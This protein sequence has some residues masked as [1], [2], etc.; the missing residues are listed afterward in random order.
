MVFS[1]TLKTT[2]ISPFLW[3]IQTPL[4]P[5]QA[6]EDIDLVILVGDIHTTSHGLDWAA[7]TF[8]QT[9]TVYI[10]SN[11]EYYD[12]MPFSRGNGIL[13]NHAD[14]YRLADHPLY[15]LD[16]DAIVVD[17]ARV[18][19]TTLWMDLK[20]HDNADEMKLKANDLINGYRKI[21]W[22]VGESLTPEHTIQRHRESEAYLEKTLAEDFD[23]KTVVVTHHLP[24]ET[25][26]FPD[27]RPPYDYS[28]PFFASNLDDLI[29]NSGADLWVFGHTHSSHDYKI[30]DTRMVCNP[31]GYPNESKTRFDSGLIV[32][33]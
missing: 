32:K 3:S 21:V 1:W 31:R 11:H 16:N 4:M 25:A 14:S 13:Q 15:V 30:G 17:G 22:D 9:K 28:N 26:C 27:Y 5:T 2:R 7:K 19:G 20:L 8:G 18:I 12:G 6:P 29:I 24:N 23:G 33:V 10:L